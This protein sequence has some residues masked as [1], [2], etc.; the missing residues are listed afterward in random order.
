MPSVE[1]MGAPSSWR[2]VPDQIDG[3]SIPVVR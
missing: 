3:R 2:L 1:P